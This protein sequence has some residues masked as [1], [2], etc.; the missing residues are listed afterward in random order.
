[1]RIGKHPYARHFRWL[2]VNDTIF[3]QVN[4]VDDKW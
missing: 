1:M 2:M 4:E 3:E